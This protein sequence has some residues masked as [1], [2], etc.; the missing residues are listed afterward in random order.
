[1]QHV[2]GPIATLH[3]DDATRQG[4][5]P[6]S[7]V[8]LTT[9]HGTTILPAAID[10]AQRPGEV[11]VPMHWTDG[12]TAAG[13]IAHL[14]GAACDPVS[15][16][17]ELKATLLVID[18]VPAHW[19]GLM[20]H[21]HAVRPDGAPDDAPRGAPRGIHW[22]RVPLEHGHAFT[23]VGH[24]ALPHGQ[25][26]A[27]ATR[28]MAAGDAEII[29]MVDRSRGVYRYAAMRDGRLMACLYLTSGTSALPS[30]Q[31]LAALMAGPVAD[32][33]RRT[34]LAGGGPARQAEKLV[35]ACFS[36][37]LQT[38]QAAVT[39]QHLTTVVEI[40]AALR[41]GT[42]CGSCI[43]ELKEILREQLATA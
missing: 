31:A 17:P 21:A 24:E 29:A 25:V 7:L 14:V 3:P 32:V 30:H 16:Q 43:P 35:C 26:A 41:A 10:P 22:S 39:N 34:V 40:G 37:G 27:F 8:R 18:P 9:P 42:N 20:L 1:M 33:A 23:L 13:P 36:V 5:T 2:A 38:L 19:R 12:F 28:L 11:F 6:G 15:G 4:I